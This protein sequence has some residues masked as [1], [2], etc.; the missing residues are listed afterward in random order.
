MDGSN[1]KEYSSL[2]FNDVPM[3]IKQIQSDGNN[4]FVTDNNA[5]PEATEIRV[6]DFHSGE[7]TAT[8]PFPDKVSP[9]GDRTIVSTQDGKLLMFSLFSYDENGVLPRKFFYCNISDIGTDNFQW[10]EVEKVN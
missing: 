6:Y 10:Y 2:D 4:V 8:I 5:A 9:Y 3:W 7:H 1:R